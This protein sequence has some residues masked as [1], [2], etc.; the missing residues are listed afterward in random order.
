MVRVE[1]QTKF[2]PPEGEPSGDLCLGVFVV[3]CEVRQTA[4]IER[5]KWLAA[6]DILNDSTSQ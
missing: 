1:R 6:L 4:T 5:G 3:N 2:S